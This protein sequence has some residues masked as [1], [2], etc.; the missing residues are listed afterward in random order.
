MSSGTRRRPPQPPERRRLDA[1]AHQHGQTHTRDTHIIVRRRPLNNTATTGSSRR[2]AATAAAKRGRSWARSRAGR[3]IRWRD[4]GQAVGSHPRPCECTLDTPHTPRA[5]TAPVTTSC[6]NGARTASP[7]SRDDEQWDATATTNT[8]RST[9]TR[10]CGARARTITHAR[11]AH[12][13]Q[14][15]DA[16]Q[17]GHHGLVTPISS[18]SSSQE[19]QELGAIASRKA[20]SAARRRPSRKEPPTAM[21]R[22]VGR[23]HTPRATPAP[24]TSSNSCDART[25][26]RDWRR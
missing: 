17:H 14:K 5:T 26:S 10:R 24:A 2:S 3:R 18:N 6:S 19:G 12:H 1:A 20:H 8:T 7:D 13:S 15:A 4:G 9:T 11:H 16:Q 21:R 25:D 22:H 23:P